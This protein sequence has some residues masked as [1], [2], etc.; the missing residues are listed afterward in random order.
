[1]T[2]MAV[3]YISGSFAAPCLIDPDVSRGEGGAGNLLLIFD[4]LFYF[5]LRTF[6]A[7]N[8]TNKVSNHV[9]EG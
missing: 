8:N 6:A 4:W 9:S 3:R 1:M 2:E 7:F 5:E